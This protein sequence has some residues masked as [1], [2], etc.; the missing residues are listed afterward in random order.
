[1]KSSG[2]PPLQSDV[3]TQPAMDSVVAVRQS[4]NHPDTAPSGGGD[5]QTLASSSKKDA[6]RRG[7]K[8]KC[9]LL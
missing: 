2:R 3:C 9:L 7:S 5:V 8:N 4:R 1:M 6:S